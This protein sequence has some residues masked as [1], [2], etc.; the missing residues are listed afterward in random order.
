MPLVR[1]CCGAVYIVCLK[2]VRTFMK[3]NLSLYNPQEKTKLNVTNRPMGLLVY[4]VSDFSHTAEREQYRTIC[5][6]LKARYSGRPELCIFV[7]NW[8]IYDSELDGLLI[9]QDAII[10]IEFKDYGGKITAVENGDWKKDDGTVVKGGVRKNPYK[11]AQINRSNL[12]NGLRDS[13]FVNPSNLKHISSL[14]V[15]NQP[16]ELDSSGISRKTKSWLH[17]CDNEHFIDKVEDITSPKTNFSDAELVKLV[18]DL[19][20]DCGGDSLDERFSDLI[21]PLL[22]DIPEEYMPEPQAL[23]ISSLAT[24]DS[25]LSVG[26]TIPGANDSQIPAYIGIDFG[27]STTVVSVARYFNNRMTCKTVEIAY[28]TFDGA[29]GRDDRIATMLANKDGKLLA[30]RGAEE[31]KYDLEKNVD[32]WYSF[33]MELG[34]DLGEQYSKSSRSDIKSPK[35]AAKLFFKYLKKQI[36]KSVRASKYEYV[37]TIPASFEANQRRDLIEALE[38]NGINISKQALIDEPNAAFLSNVIEDQMCGKS[39]MLRPDSNL[40]ILVFD[41][42]A[43]TCDV[44]ILEVG[45]DQRGA[46]SKNKAISRFERCGGDD[47]DRCIATKILLPQ[48][49]EQI[50]E[51]EEDLRQN[52]KQELINHLMKP[53][54]LLKIEICER[55]ANQMND[56]ILPPLAMSEDKVSLNT[57]YRFEFD[58]RWVVFS[59]PQMSYKEFNSIMMNFLK[60]EYTEKDEYNSI[61]KSIK[62]AIDKSGLTRNDIDYVLL[63]G[64]SSYNPYIQYALREHFANS[65]LRIPRDL[66]AHVSQGAAV[67]SLIYHGLNHNIINPISSEPIFVITKGIKNK[68]ILIPAGTYMPSEDVLVDDLETSSDGQ[69]CIELPIC[70]GDENKILSNF[71]IQAPDSS[72]FRMGESVKLKIRLTADKLLKGH[73]EVRGRTY[74]IDP[75]NPLSNKAL[76]ADEAAILRAQRVVNNDAS[77]NHGRASVRTLKDLA[78][79]YSEAGKHLDAAET[80]EDI[81]E[82]YPGTISL[83]NIA[84]EYGEAGKKK[85]KMQ[86]LEQALKEE[87]DNATIIFNVAYNIK[88]DDSKRYRELLEKS[89]SLSPNDPSHLYDFGCWLRNHNERQRGQDMID[90]ALQIW[91]E[92]FANGRMMSWDYGW[93]A[94]A[95][96]SIGDY[97]K[98]REVREA[99][100]KN[101]SEAF[102]TDNLT[103]IR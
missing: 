78:N 103:Q 60:Q 68:R 85:R 27:T 81:N 30:G 63:I 33:K 38:A 7:A 97:T 91:K 47:I 53:A 51:H 14:I 19:N 59:N 24:K 41:Y 28:Q 1:V 64:G 43:G 73:V 75:I 50:M 87:P 70:V 93:Y 21:D 74:E 100:R 62:T 40:S 9:K 72:G 95:L 56:G 15:F 76:S 79:A 16:I 98:A 2:N 29:I 44:S 101:R 18:S 83:N 96:E 90:Q 6:M 99:M 69:S 23:T 4:K 36:E 46:F 88:G 102:N 39:M 77:R 42:G 22:E 25:L 8:N 26:E 13:G 20:F 89:I 92:R 11:Q 82:L 52:K 57:S 48:I 17:I 67:H 35:D 32:I 54:E 84:L 86:M 55:V 31:F 10:A 45:L 80:Y 58:G 65:T 49:L 37:V 71:V 12:L 3:K 34:E 5:Q 66:Q 61:F 94:S